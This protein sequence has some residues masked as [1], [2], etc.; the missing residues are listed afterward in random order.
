MNVNYKVP[1]Y[2]R[3]PLVSLC[4]TVRVL[5]TVVLVELQ[6]LALAAVPTAGASVPGEK[7]SGPCRMEPGGEEQCSRISILTV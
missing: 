7:V 5:G 1:S 6:A 4:S 2:H 3:A